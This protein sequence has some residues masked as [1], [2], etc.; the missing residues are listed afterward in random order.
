MGSRV[1][2]AKSL[3]DFQR[4]FFD[5]I[6]ERRAAPQE[7]L[8]SE[9]C[10]A[11]P[12]DGL[13]PLT[14]PEILAMLG[15][16]VVGATETTRSA[17]ASLIAHSLVTPGQ[18][19]LLLADPAAIANAIDETLRFQSP[20][21]AAFRV[22]GRDAVLG[23]ISIPARSLLMLRLDSAGRDERVFA[24]ADRFDVRRK[25][26]NRHLGFGLGAHF[27]VGHVLA[28]RELS[29]AI[30]KVLSRLKNMKLDPRSDLRNFPTINTHALREIHITFDPGLPITAQT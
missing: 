18:L 17:I 20:G 28:R 3:L 19:E 10:R 30:P 14:D 23:G 8:L 22:A 27:C 29:I 16:V 2:C 1:E 5:K 12:A 15:M 7:D 13:R 9:L 25:N 11:D 21:A 24:N 26:A 4:Y 6:Q